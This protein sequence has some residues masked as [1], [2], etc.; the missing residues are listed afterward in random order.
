[1]ELL[2]RWTNSILDGLAH[3]NAGDS[4]DLSTP[5]AVLGPMYRDDAPAR[6]NGSSMIVNDHNGYVTYMHGKVLD[7]TTKQPIKGACIQVWQASSNGLYDQ[8]DQEQMT[9]N[10]R[11]VFQTD[12]KGQY[13]W[14][15]LKP[16][17]YPIP[18]ACEHVT[19]IFFNNKLIGI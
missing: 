5:T 16:T 6:E 9:G 10:L 3:K 14:Y 11:G 2:T 12:E 4:N 7:S 8:E 15:C 19:L 1:M 18:A 13:S 17:P